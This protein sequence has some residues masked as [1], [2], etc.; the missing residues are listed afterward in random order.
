MA[1]DFEQ[2]VTMAA[3]PYVGGIAKFVET[4][5]DK[6]AGKVDGVSRRLH[7]VNV[8]API[9]PRGVPPNAS[10]CSMPTAGCSSANTGRRP[11]C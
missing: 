3:E 6:L 8:K 4:L 9:P 11:S 1:R 10:E 7:D 5:Q 2:A